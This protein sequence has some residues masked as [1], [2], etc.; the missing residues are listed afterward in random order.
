MAQLC[1]KK[2]LSKCAI[3]FREL[4][5]SCQLRSDRYS[6]V[7][8]NASLLVVVS[9]AVGL[10][11][12]HG[13]VVLV[14]VVHIRLLVIGVVVPRVRILVWIWLLVWPRGWRIRVVHICSAVRIVLRPRVGVESRCWLRVVR[15]ERRL[16]RVLLDR[17]WRLGWVIWVSSNLCTLARKWVVS[18]VL[19][20]VVHSFLWLLYVDETWVILV[21][22]G[23][24][25]SE[26]SVLNLLIELRSV[27]SHACFELGG[28]LVA[29]NIEYFQ[30]LFAPSLSEPYF[31]FSLGRNK[32]EQW[33]HSEFKVVGAKYRL[34]EI[35][36]PHQRQRHVKRFD[37]VCLEVF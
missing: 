7:V 29:R 26:K 25:V 30:E 36:V 15:I 35:C 5:I 17:P 4:V 2:V 9:S 6:K 20:G 8:L 28:D 27:R 23:C 11:V 12:V 22:E 18:I 19:S 16:G 33:E 10:W 24:I 37:S 32:I 21:L 34:L 3:I 14:R 1:G 31:Y 13:G